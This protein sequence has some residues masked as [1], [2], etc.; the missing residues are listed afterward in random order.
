MFSTTTTN[1]D[2]GNGNL[3]LDNATQAS[4]TTIRADLL[5][6]LGTTWTAV[7]DSLDDATGP[8]KG[9][10]RLVKTTDAT[11]WLLF[12]VSAVDNST[13]YRN[14]TV[15]NVAS[16]G[17]DPFANSDPVTLVYTR[18]GDLGTTGAT[19]A[20]GSTG[21][22]GPQGNTG[23]TGAAASFTVTLMVSDPNGSE[24][25]TGD[26]KHY[27]RV[28]ALLNNRVISAVAAHVTT[29]SSSGLV[30]V[31]INNV[32]DAV[33]VLST[34]LTIDA[35]EK[36]SSTAATAAVI[37]TSNDDVTTADELRIDIDGAGTGAK[38]L[39]VELTFS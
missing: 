8:L 36:D 1:S 5:D 20:Q 30:N 17:A 7:L 15:A 19:G 14:I 25:T 9:H 16:S 2:P 37:N 12:T 27:Y 26:G 29:V 11:K 22:T 39:M 35:N 23:A 28:P 3:R 4:A 34:A 6:S 24:I 10:I 33:D 32:T 13:G 31:Q 21:A 18:G 38:G